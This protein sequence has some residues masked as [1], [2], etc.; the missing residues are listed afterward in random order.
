[1]KSTKGRYTVQAEA[2]TIATLIANV[3]T[4]FEAAMGWAA[5][6][7]EAIA[8]DPLLLMFV[9]IPMVGLG[10]GLFRRLLGMR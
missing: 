10:V 9:L 8:G 6:V 4:V 7:G 1:M 5:K 3:T 2:I